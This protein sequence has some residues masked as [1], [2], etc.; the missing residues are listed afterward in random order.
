MARQP[1]VRRHDRHVVRVFSASTNAVTRAVSSLAVPSSRTGS[2]TN[3]ASAVLLALEPANPLG[4][5]AHAFV[6][7]FRP[8]A[9]SAAARASRRIAD[10]EADPPSSDINRSTRTTQLSHAAT[11]RR[12]SATAP[13]RDERRWFYFCSLPHC[14]CAAG[15]AGRAPARRGAGAARDRSAAGAAERSR[16]AGGGRSGRCSAICESWKSIARS[17]PKSSGS[18]GGQRADFRRARR[19]QAA[20][21]RARAAGSRKPARAARQA[22]RHLQDGPGPLPQAPAVHLR[23]PSGRPGV[24]HRWARWRSRSRARRDTSAHLHELKRPRAALEQ[25]SRD[26]SALPRDA[27]RAQA[28]AGARGRGAQRADPR[29]RH[30]RDL[31]AQLSGELQA[32]Q[33]KLQ[34]TL[35]DLGAATAR[36][37]LRAAARVRSA[38]TSTGRSRATRAAASA[39]APA[40]RPAN[41]ID[42][43]AA[44]GTALSPSTTAWSRLPDRSRGFGN[45]VIVDHGAQTFSLYGNLLEMTVRKG[46]GSNAASRSARS[47]RRRRAGRAVLRASRRRSA[48]RSFTM[49]E[50]K[51]GHDLHAPASSSCRFPRRSIAF[52]I[53]GGFLGKVMA[54]EDTYPHL[55]DLRRRGEPDLEQLRRKGEHRQGDDAARCTVSPTASI[56]TARISSPDEVKQVESGRAA[57]A[58][59]RRPRADAAVLSAR[60][61]GARQLAGGEGRAAHRRLRPRDQRHADARNVACGKAC[62]RCAARPAR[63]SRSRSSAATPPIRTSSSSRAR[64]C[65]RR[66]HRPHRG[67]RRRLRARRRDRPAARPIR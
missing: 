58:G 3:D 44:E 42:I 67:A 46:A 18:C 48:G 51:V 66:R 15:S 29:H 31:N 55:Q 4:D 14:R 20:D 27:E 36:A 11:C 35:R 22:R 25:R 16:P 10:R 19:E 65:R 1:L 34:A 49:A 41:G 12:C 17:R 45:L 47:G 61:R 38:A 59:R 23:Y 33:Q 6:A 28:G 53:V 56:P 5:T 43:A 9:S 37:S 63:K 60:H 40:R 50:E 39:V 26:L 52:A 62:A 30:R 2:P 21:A 7:V 8:R 57:A 24:A 13:C 54:R 32:A 64:R